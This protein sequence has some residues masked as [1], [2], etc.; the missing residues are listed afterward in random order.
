ME[1]RGIF[2]D[3][4]WTPR[5]ANAKDSGLSGVVMY[6]GITE[7]LREVFMYVNCNIQMR[8]TKGSRRVKQVPRR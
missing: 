5:K 8:K 1:R 6:I 3:S 2:S 4:N 7:T